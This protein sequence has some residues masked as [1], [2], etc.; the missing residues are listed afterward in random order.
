MKVTKLY[1]IGFCKGVY[2]AIQIVY[3]TIEENKDED[4]YCIGQIVHNKDINDKLIANG[5]KIIS[6]NKEDIIDSIDKGIVIFSAHGTDPKIIQKAQD[7]GL[8]VI[9]TVCQFVMDNMNLI[10]KYLRDGYDVIY[11]GKKGHPEAEAALSLSNK[12]HLYENNQNTNLMID[13]D[14]IFVCNQTTM[15]LYDIKKTFDEL[16]EK[17]QNAIFADEICDA[18]RIRQEQ[19][20]NKASNYDGVIVVGDVNSNNSNSL[21]SLALINHCDAI[22]VNDYAEI[23]PNWLKNKKNI[24]LLSGTSTP[25]EKVNDIEAKLR[26]LE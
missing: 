8:K 15:S 13:S 9:D 24:C 23:N 6:G 26:E 14:K 1:P 10:V 7:K 17:Y 22:L 5:V 2:D 4:I 21:K 25:I 3:K 19:V 11:V 12:V 20:L 18:T 16:K